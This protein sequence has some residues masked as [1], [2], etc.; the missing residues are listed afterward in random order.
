M[1]RPKDKEMEA[2]WEALG[3]SAASEPPRPLWPLIHARLG[4]R[5]TRRLRA[6]FA[7]SASAA[8]VTGVLLGILLGSAGQSAQD[9]WQQETW[10]E[11]GSM[12]ADG[13]TLTLGDVYLASQADEGDEGP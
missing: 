10:A 11:V 3:A 6:L 12:L 2:V 13:T 7:L 5:P 4:Q 8:A 1:T 9:Q